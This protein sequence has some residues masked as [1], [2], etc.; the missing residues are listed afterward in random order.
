M[1]LEPVP[2]IRLG[3]NDRKALVA[4]ANG[5]RLEPDFTTR[6]QIVLALADGESI[7]NVANRVGA[8]RATVRKWRNRYLNEGIDSI[9]RSR[10]G[11]TS[12]SD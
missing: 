11:K 8:H 5:D 10:P 6:A 4:L 7:I 12:Q 9:T 3:P 2:Q 1:P